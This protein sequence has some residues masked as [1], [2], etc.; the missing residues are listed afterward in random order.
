[1]KVDY[2]VFS[3]HLKTIIIQKL[4]YYVT[5]SNGSPR[6]ISPCHVVFLFVKHGSPLP[7]GY[8]FYLF[9]WL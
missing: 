2:N 3:T 1:M 9:I 5:E 8:V 7:K 6:D 4:G